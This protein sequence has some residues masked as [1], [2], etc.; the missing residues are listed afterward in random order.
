MTLALG[1]QKV[2]DSAKLRNHRRVASRSTRSPR[3]RSL[4]RDDQLGLRVAFVLG[5]A[6]FKTHTTQIRGVALQ[7]SGPWIF[8]DPS[9]S[10]SWTLLRPLFGTKLDLERPIGPDWQR[11]RLPVPPILVAILQHRYVPHLDARSVCVP[12]QRPQRPNPPPLPP[13]KTRAKPKV[14]ESR[15]K[16][17]QKPLRPGGRTSS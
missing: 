3:A 4:G 11:I 1:P 16:R 7:K 15:I 13:R 5:G 6:L 17:G 9:P 14:R 10:R 2:E 8:L 12:S